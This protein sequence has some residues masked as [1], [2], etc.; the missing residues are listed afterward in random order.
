MDENEALKKMAKHNRLVA[1]SLASNK[2]SSSKI[3]D[4]IKGRVSASAVADAFEARIQKR[5]KELA[6]WQHSPGY[7]RNGILIAELANTP[8]GD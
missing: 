5:Y 7:G 2:S 8:E 1:E 6:D 4:K 3:V